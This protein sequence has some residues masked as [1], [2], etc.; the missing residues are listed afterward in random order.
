[1]FSLISITGQKCLDPGYP[2]GGEI[3]ATS[4][5]DKSTVSFTCDRAGYSLSRNVNLTCQGENFFSN[6]ESV[7]TCIGMY[8]PMTGF[9]VIGS[10]SW[11]QCHM[12]VIT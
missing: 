8:S 6:G 9:K 7:P 11:F 4:F 10:R 3:V 1:M 12:Q 2:A 5:A